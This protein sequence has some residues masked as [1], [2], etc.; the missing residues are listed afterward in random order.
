MS[1][2][3]TGSVH[4]IKEI[5]EY[6]SKLGNV[7]KIQDIVIE[8]QEQFKQYITVQFANENI[9]NLSQ[10]EV[11]DHVSVEYFLSGR[12]WTDPETN[13]LKYITT[14]KGGRVRKDEISTFSSF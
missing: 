14:L 8:T 7:L 11:N 2:V 9:N 10:I 4:L 13:E 6:E 3:V 1:N 5:K 12:Q